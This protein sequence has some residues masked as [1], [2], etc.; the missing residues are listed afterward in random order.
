MMSFGF[1]PIQKIVVLSSAVGDYLEINM[2]LKE[3]KNRCFHTEEFRY[4]DEDGDAHCEKCESEL[5]R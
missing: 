5:K 4:I 2:K 1:V 3:Q